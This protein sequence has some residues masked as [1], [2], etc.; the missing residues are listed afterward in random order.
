[1]KF[2]LQLICCMGSPTPSHPGKRFLSPGKSFALFP[3]KSIFKTPHSSKQINNSV[4]LFLDPEPQLGKSEE[5][6]NQRMKKIELLEAIFF[7]STTT[8]KII[9]EQTVSRLNFLETP[10]QVCRSLSN[11]YFNSHFFCYLHFSKDTSNPKS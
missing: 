7:L 3:G 6:K 8:K 1:M 5:L 2:I 4:Y 9:K 11:L 10:L